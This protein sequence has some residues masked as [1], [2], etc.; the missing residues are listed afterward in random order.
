MMVSSFIYTRI[1]YVSY[2]T[3]P[4]LKLSSN[5]PINPI[6]NPPHCCLF[7]FLFVFPCLKQFKSYTKLVDKLVIIFIINFIKE[8]EDHIFART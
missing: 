8:F 3:S 6:P 1:H 2:S 5:Q 4:N 7:S